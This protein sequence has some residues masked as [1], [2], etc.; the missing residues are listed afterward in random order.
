MTTGTTDKAVEAAADRAK[1]VLETAKS[2][3]QQVLD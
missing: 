2:A 3:E 1:T